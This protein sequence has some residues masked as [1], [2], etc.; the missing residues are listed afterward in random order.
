MAQSRPPDL[1]RDGVPFV[2]LVYEAFTK[3][4]SWPSEVDIR[5]TLAQQEDLNSIRVGLGLHDW[6]VLFHADAQNAVA[7]HLAAVVGAYGNTPITSDFLLLLQTTIA[8]WKEAGTP[9]RLQESELAAVGL[10]RER[11]KYVNAFYE[12]NVFIVGPSGNDA[13]YYYDISLGIEP[14]LSAKTLQEFLETLWNERYRGRAQEEAKASETL[15]PIQ[16]GGGAPLGLDPALSFGK[17]VRRDRISGG[18]NADVYRA[19]RDDLAEEVALKILRSHKVQSEPYRRFIQEVKVLRDLGA[20]DG[21]LPVIDANLPERPSE[22]NPAWLAMPLATPIAEALVGQ[23]ID[24]AVEAIAHVADT[25]ARLARRNISHRDI[26]PGNLYHRDGQWL[27]GDFG[28]VAIPEGED[29]TLNDKQLGP[30]HFIAYEMVVDP[31]NADPK[32]ADVYSLA[33]TLWVLA[34][35]R[36]YPPPGRQ[37]STEAGLR[38]ADLKPGARVELLDG[39]IDRATSLKPEARPTVEAVAGDLH[40]WLLLRASQRE[41]RTPKIDVSDLVDRFRAKLRAEIEAEN[42][43]KERER[44]ATVASA[45]LRRLSEGLDESLTQLDARAQIGRFDHNLRAALHLPETLGTSRIVFQDEHVSSVSSGPEGFPYS[46]IYG[47]GLDLDENGLATLHTAVYVGHEEVMG[48]DFW[49]QGPIRRAQ[50]GSVE[51]ARFSEEAIQELS[52][53]LREAL[54]A[55]ENGLGI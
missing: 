21:I 22:K 43:N 38:V 25:L 31:V 29:I 52:P 24:V 16:E 13:G 9:P 48:S 19:T 20:F 6:F 35:G 12:K 10:T 8:R 14:Y 3:D 11:M 4:G 42:I 47:W 15:P 23:P 28:L 7:L 44:L 53:K 17:W 46:T 39:L 49:F 2:K 54:E 26:K 33:K 30:Q 40:E 51:L 36:R 45:R 1:P 18:G 27:I 50:V 34:V 5:R 32:A 37:V 55:Y 41:P